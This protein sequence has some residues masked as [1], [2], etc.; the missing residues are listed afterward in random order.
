MVCQKELKRVVG[1]HNIPYN[2]RHIPTLAFL[3]MNCGGTYY[4]FMP[5]RD[6]LVCS[7]DISSL[8]KYKYTR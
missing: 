3:V 8:V 4:V 5:C 1:I 2:Y 6:T 7:L